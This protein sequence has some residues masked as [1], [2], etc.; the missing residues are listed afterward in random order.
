MN[1]SVII[2]DVSD[3]LGINRDDVAYVFDEIFKV[4][5]NNMKEAKPMGIRGFG[6]FTYKYLPEKKKMFLGKWVKVEGKH[7]AKFTPSATIKES[8]KEIK[9]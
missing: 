2:K 3:N 6:K 9:K 1:K 8:L 5:A 7:L 4:M